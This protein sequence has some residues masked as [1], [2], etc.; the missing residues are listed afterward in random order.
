MRS[1]VFRCR[2][3]LWS[4]LVDDELAAGEKEFGEKR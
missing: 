4:F 1:D 2:E 3:V